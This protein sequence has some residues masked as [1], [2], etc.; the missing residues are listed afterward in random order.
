L[1]RRWIA[2]VDWCASNPDRTTRVVAEAPACVGPHSTYVNHDETEGEYDECLRPATVERL[3]RLAARHGTS[4]DRE[5]SHRSRAL[6][7]DR[8]R[9]RFTDGLCV[10]GRPDV[11][12]GG[13]LVVGDSITWRGT[14]ELGE[15]RP[16]L[17]L[18]GMPARQPD[19][20]RAR[21][22]RYRADHGQPDGLV[23]ELGTNRNRGYSIGDLWDDIG[24]LPP[25]SVVMMVLPYRADR[26]RTPVVTPSS[27]RFAEWMA[28][29]A[30]ARPRTCV[31]DWRAV[32]ANHPHVVGDGVHPRSS[33]ERYWARWLSR[34]WSGCL[35][36]FEAQSADS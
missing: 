13:V 3:R 18:D 11:A 8:P 6:C 35:G 36:Q 10:R 29:V 23:V 7:A 17:V 4:L 26:S 27:T 28:A 15:L 30:A 19:E 24:S 31:A 12:Q 9:H 1:H 16:D 14:D 2:P 33:K 5:A 22:D 21:L 25:D 32:V 34:S 20:L